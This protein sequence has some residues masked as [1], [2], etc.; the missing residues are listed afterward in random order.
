M[1]IV[2]LAAARAALDVAISWQKLTNEHKATV[3]AKLDALSDARSNKG[4]GR[5]NTVHASKKT[6]AE[7]E[8]RRLERGQLPGEAAAPQ[9]ATRSA[10]EQR[11]SAA[12]NPQPWPTAC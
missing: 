10:E 2:P 7:W 6:A 4:R 12:Q 5:P 11:A 9:T 3:Q 1:A 8:M